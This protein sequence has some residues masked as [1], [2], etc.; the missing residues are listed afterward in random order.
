LLARASWIATA[1]A[2][3]GAG[4]LSA[5]PA[6]ATPPP[7][8]NNLLKQSS[9]EMPVPSGD[10]QVFQP[11]QHIGR[12]QVSGQ[13]VA[14]VVPDVVDG[15]GTQGMQFLSLNE[16]SQPLPPTGTVC[17]TVPL[18]P[19]DRYALAFSSADIVAAATLTV[20]W[21]GSSVAAIDDPVS[22]VGNGTTWTRHRV[23]LGKAN[24]ATSGTVCFGGTQG[25]YLLLDLVVIQ[26]VVPVCRLAC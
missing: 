11:G 7:S 20:S 25:G 10:E 24:G 4:A 2:L 8:G 1:V 5:T 13:Q 6:G 14:V 21:Q 15:T 19:A 26:P 18:D 16:P 23:K 22:V 12:W 17:Q 9:F 3:V